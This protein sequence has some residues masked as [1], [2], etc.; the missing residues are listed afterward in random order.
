VSRVHFLVTVS[1]SKEVGV[2]SC[3]EPRGVR[4]ITCDKN[5]TGTNGIKARRDEGHQ[6]TKTNTIVVIFLTWK[7]QEGKV[8]C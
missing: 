5:D 1:L 4:Q 7:L 6:V 8:R 2:M 3:I